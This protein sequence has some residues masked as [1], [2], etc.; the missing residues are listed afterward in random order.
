MMIIVGICC[1]HLAA[2]V[3]SWRDDFPRPRASVNLHPKEITDRGLLLSFLTGKPSPKS[4]DKVSPWVL[5]P[6]AVRAPDLM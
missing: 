3:P 5:L 1:V 4:R 2:A 6:R